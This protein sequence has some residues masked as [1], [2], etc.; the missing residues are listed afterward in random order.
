MPTV[1]PTILSGGKAMDSTYQLLSI[2][3]RREVNRIPRAELRLADGS[4]AKQRFEISDTRFF[5]PG[6]EV[7]IKLRYEGQED[8]TVF[9]GL[10]VRQGVEVSRDG[11]VLVVGIKDAAVKLTASRK[12]AVF[13]KKTD[14]AIIKR[15]V[16]AAG[17]KAGKLAATAPEHLTMVQYHATSW[18]FILSRA[19]AQ[20]LLVVVEDGKLSLVE[21]THRGSTEHRFELGIDEIFDVEMEADGGDQYEGVESVAWNPREHRPT[22]PRKA[23]DVTASPGNLDGKKLGKSVGG[24]TLTLSHPVPLAPKELAAWADATLARSRMALCRGRLSVPGFAGVKLLDALAI[25]GIGKRFNGKTVV[26]GLRHSL[27]DAGW[28]TDLQFGLPPEGFARS[29]H[30]IEAPAAGLL[31]AVN[32]LQIGVVAEFAEDPDKELRVKVILPG[33]DAKK[34]F[35]WARLAAPDAGKDRG[36]C[37]RPEPKDEVVVGFLNGDPRHPVILGALHGS[38]NSAPERFGAPSDKNEK[39]GI[40]TRKGTVIGFTDGDKASVFIETAGKNK[41]LLDDDAKK[42]VLSDEHGNT[43]TM[44]KDGITLKSAKDLKL[45]ADGDVKIKG[46]KFKLGASGDCELKG[47]AVKVEAQSGVELKGAT[48]KLDASGAVTIKGS[49][50]DIQ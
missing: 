1:T 47:N 27:D 28:R 11:S 37:F 26:T 12:S 14:D 8:K 36:W 41:L 33:V 2:D 16:E 34:G 30:I 6:A 23:R 19:D 42:I 25:A 40:V 18:D 22:E 43:I 20:G 7:E 49:K 32:G 21:M 13:E 48:A 44:S 17:L 38:K 50:V 45:E 4:I 15:L 9:K 39:K 35:V 31:P 24:G 3:V 5:E 29:E 10:V 46:K